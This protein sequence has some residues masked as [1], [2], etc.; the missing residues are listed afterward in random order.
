M[1]AKAVFLLLMLVLTASGSIAQHP[2]GT[3]IFRDLPYVTDGHERQK[4]DLYL[5]KSENKLPLIIWIHGGAFMAGS[6]ENGVPL[7][8]LSDGYALASINYRLSQHA[9]FPAQIQDCKA[10]VCR[11]RR[12]A[13]KLNIE[14]RTASASGARRQGDTWSQCLAQ[15]AMSTSLR[16]ARIS[17][18]PAKCRRWSIT[19]AQPTFCKWTTIVHLTAKY[20][21]SRTRRSRC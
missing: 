9:I 20:I 14:T 15:R 12:L 4:L 11:L 3:L 7:Q 21:T 6:K 2:E 8:Y 18:I 19:S 13:D 1:K 5:P 17:N 16:S 10:A